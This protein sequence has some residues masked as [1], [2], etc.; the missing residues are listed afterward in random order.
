MIK[1][2]LID[3]LTHSKNSLSQRSYKKISLEAFESFDQT[4]S[5]LKELTSNVRDIVK[6]EKEFYVSYAYKMLNSLLSQFESSLNELNVQEITQDSFKSF[7]TNLI[8]FLSQIEE[9]SESLIEEGDI[10]RDHVMIL[11]KVLIK[12]NRF[13]HYDDVKYKDLF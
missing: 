9:E 12:E 3:S 13:A 6:E 4:I 10:M 5:N 2:N 1:N 11:K 8:A 7:E